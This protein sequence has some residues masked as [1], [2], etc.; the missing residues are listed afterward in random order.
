LLVMPVL[1]VVG[2]PDAQRWRATEFARPG[3]HPSLIQG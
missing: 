2:L 3:R 1:S